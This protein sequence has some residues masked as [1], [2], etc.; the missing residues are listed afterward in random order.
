MYKSFIHII[1]SH[2][3]DFLPY[4]LTAVVTLEVSNRQQNDAPLPWMN[5][6]ISLSLLHIVRLKQ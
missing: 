2:V 5:V 6:Q 4:S 3:F 1:F